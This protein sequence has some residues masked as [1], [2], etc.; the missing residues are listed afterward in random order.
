M[1]VR[2]AKRIENWWRHLLDPSPFSGQV[3]PLSTAYS[4]RLMF[5]ESWWRV[6]KTSVI[7]T[8]KV[9]TIMRRLV[10]WQKIDLISNQVEFMCFLT[11]YCNRQADKETQWI[12]RLLFLYGNGYFFFLISQNIHGSGWAT[13]N[14]CGSSRQPQRKNPPDFIPKDLCFIFS[15]PPFVRKLFTH[16]A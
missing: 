2:V 14:V 1:S 13:E 7:E 3:R 6:A 5:Q 8:F 11:R 10:Q 9:Y 16:V 15:S 12:Y 4:K